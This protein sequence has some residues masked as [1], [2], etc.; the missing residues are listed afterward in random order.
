MYDDDPQPDPEEHL[1]LEQGSGRVWLVKIPK[2]LMERW[3]AIDA[4]NVQLATIRVYDPVGNKKPRIILFLPP[5]HGPSSDLSVPQSRSSEPDC[6]ELEMV[7]ESVENQLVV[8]ERPKE[9]SL[10]AVPGNNTHNTRARTTILTGRIRHDCNLRPA[11]SAKYRKQMRE[12][13][14][15]YN[16]PVRQIRMIEDA[17]VPGGRGAVNRLS[18]GVGMGATTAFNDLV[19]TKPKPPK[20]TFERMARMPRN[21]LLDEIFRHFRDTPRWGIRLLR[22]KTQQPEAYLKEVLSEVAFLH[23]SGE[24]NGLWELK[25]NFKDENIRAENIPRP[26][27]VGV[28]TVTSDI[29]MEGDDEDQEDEDADMEMVS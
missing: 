2:F 28:G 18:S 19:K 7:N 13:N 21:Q 1:M 20:G 27:T 26:D 10:S 25:D 17:G 22:E 12:R 4:E 8:A 11:F 15:K 16:T 24:H 9:P 6:Y 14:R 29:K 5:T 3:C 23:R